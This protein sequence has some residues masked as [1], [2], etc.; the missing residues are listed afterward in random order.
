MLIG[1][2]MKKPVAALG[3]KGHLK[4]YFDPKKIYI[5]QGI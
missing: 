1:I 5:G 2:K 3:H 4:I